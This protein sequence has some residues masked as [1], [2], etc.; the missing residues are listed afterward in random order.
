MDKRT[1]SRMTFLANAGWAGA[2]VSILAAD[3]S[4]RSYYRVQLNERQCVLMDAPPPEEDIRP[5]VIVAR[6]LGQLGF[7]APRILAEDPRRG[8][9]LL[10]D[11]GDDTYTR[12]FEAGGDQALLYDAAV[13][14]LVHLHELSSAK[15]APPE[16][17]TYDMDRLLAE[18]KLFTDWYMPAVGTPLGDQARGAFEAAWRSV[19]ASVAEKRETLVLRDYH[20]DNLMWLPGR[21]A[22]A[23]CGLLDFQD[24]L[25]GARAYD[26]MSLIEDARRDV[27]HK[28]AD[29]LIAR[30]VAACGDVRETDLR[31]D[32]AI[33][34]AGRHAKVIGIFTRLYHRDGKAQYLVH[35]PRVWRL[36]EHSLSHPALAPVA[37][38]FAENVPPASR[39][40]PG[41]RPE[42]PGDPQ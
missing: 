16:I 35:I 39:V 4:F 14:T 8:F 29:R 13:D 25:I 9:L 31:R 24:A 10:E 27:D 6:Y 33:L 21:A 26:L 42:N 17:P 30:Y 1:E 18:A 22:T 5:F 19:F 36:L 34:G 37:E 11:L 12:V 7:S 15:T 41:P 2:R 23:R 20:V 32:I 3:A 38:W 40:T 28:R